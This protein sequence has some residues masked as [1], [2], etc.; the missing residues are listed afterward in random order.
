[1]RKEFRKQYY[2]SEEK[3]TQLLPNSAIFYQAKDIVSGDFYWMEKVDNKVL[4]AVVDCT[5]HGVPGAFMSILGYNGLN[6]IVIEKGITTPSKILEELTEHVINSLQQTSSGEDI[7]DGMDIALCCLDLNTNELQFSGAYN[8]L[9]LCRDGEIQIVKATR[10]P[11]GRFKRKNI[12]DFENHTIQL[13]SKDSI[14][15]FTDGIADQF[16][17]EN[18][19]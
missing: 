13:K 2:L 17:G 15:I 11:I 1:M 7:N 18:S 6:K 14:Y 5:G 12:P 19:S 4:W 10:R 16:G 3:R 8:P 9:Y